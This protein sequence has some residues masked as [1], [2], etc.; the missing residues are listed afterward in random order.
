M[1]WRELTRLKMSWF[2]LNLTLMWIDTIKKISFFVLN[3]TLTWIDTIKKCH[4]LSWI[5]LWHELTGL[6][7][8]SFVLNLTLMWID[9]IKKIPCFVLNLTL[10]WI[11]TIKKRG[12]FARSTYKFSFAWC[13]ICQT[14]PHLESHNILHI[15]WLTQT[16]GHMMTSVS[17]F[18]A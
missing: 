15:F 10:T 18:L 12:L 5:W 14:H 1:F 13:H 4:V 8:S 7:M 17:L 16:V 9:T 11:D 3:L 6:K 2:V